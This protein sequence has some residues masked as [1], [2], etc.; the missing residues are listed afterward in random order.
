MIYQQ[1]HSFN[2]YLLLTE[3]SSFSSSSALS[4]S[5]TATFVYRQYPLT[6]YTVNALYTYAMA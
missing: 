1:H 6:L 3:A 4:L 2:D 5:E